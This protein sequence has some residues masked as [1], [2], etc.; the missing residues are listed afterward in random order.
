MKRVFLIWSGLV[1]GGYVMAASQGWEL[2]GGKTGRI[3]PSV[4]NSPGGY[5]SYHFWRGGK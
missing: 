5:R 2:G 4:R 1:L 3:D